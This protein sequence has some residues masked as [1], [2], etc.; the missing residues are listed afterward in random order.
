[1]TTSGGGG[2][3]ALAYAV[4]IF[5]VFRGVDTVIDAG[6]LMRRPHRSAL[7]LWSMVAVPSIAQFAVPAIYDALSRQPDAIRDG[8]EWWRLIT[9]AYVQDGGVFGTV[10]NLVMFYIVAALAVPLWGGLRTGG[11]FVFATAAFDLPAVY[12]YPSAGGGN[13]G[14]TFF[15]AT[16]VLSMLLVRGLTRGVVVAS[17]VAVIVG[18]GL[19]VTG[20]AHGLAFTGGFIVGLALAAVTHPSATSAGSATR[21]ERR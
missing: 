18:A 1:M 20:D 15:L 10:T 9:S 16:S 13:S 21:P 14:A 8:H 2:L 19:V 6:A 12:L 17:G 11:L 3:N 7:V 5:A 4:V